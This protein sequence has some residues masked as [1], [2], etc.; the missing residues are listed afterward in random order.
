MVSVEMITYN[1]EKFIAQ[2]IEGVLMQQTNFPF[3]LIIGEDCSTDNTRQICIEYQAKYPE[4]IKLI[5][6]EKN[7]GADNNSLS[8][9]NISKGKY[10]AYCEGDD[11]WIDPFKLQKQ[12]DFLENNPDYSICGGNFLLLNE[13]TKTLKHCYWTVKPMRKYPDGRVVTLNNYL[14][15]YLLQ[16]LTICFRKEYLEGISKFETTLDDVVWGCLL[17]KGKGFMFPDV[18]SVYRQHKGGIWT[19]SSRK[20]RLSSDLPCYEELRIHLGDKSKSIRQMYLSIYID[21]LYLE[22]NYWGILQLIFSRD[23]PPTICQKLGYM[24]K[25]ICIGIGSRFI[26]IFKK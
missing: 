24:I 18:F 8:I 25:R 21:L 10:V 26:G 5:L 9:M 3:E 11:Y 23:A 16:T 7:I 4:I 15:P 17:E 14:S 22:K 2:A 1:H 6:Q 19:G 20:K 13:D 12:V